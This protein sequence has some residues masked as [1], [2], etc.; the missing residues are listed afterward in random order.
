MYAVG[1]SYGGSPEYIRDNSIKLKHRLVQDNEEMQN[2]IEGSDRSYL[3]ALIDPQYKRRFVPLSPKV[4]VMVLNYM[5][6]SQWVRSKPFEAVARV[7]TKDEKVTLI[8]IHELFF[9]TKGDKDSQ[10]GLGSGMTSG[11]SISFSDYGEDH[12][13]VAI[14]SPPGTLDNLMNPQTKIGFYKKDEQGGVGSEYSAE[15]NMAREESPSL[16]GKQNKGPDSNCCI[17]A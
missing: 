13:P 14:I 7:Y 4:T 10:F 6:P 11:A 1:S 3:I 17:L 5:P 2:L 12:R 15:L 9:R 16:R 8:K